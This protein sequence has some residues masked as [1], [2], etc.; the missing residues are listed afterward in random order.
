PYYRKQHTVDP[1]HELIQKR[2]REGLVRLL[3]ELSDSFNG[4]FL[5][6]AVATRAGWSQLADGALGLLDAFLA[7][8]DMRTNQGSLWNYDFRFIPVE[9][10]SGIY[11]T[12]LGDEQRE[13]GAYYTPP[14]KPYTTAHAARAF[15]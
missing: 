8:V 14:P 15:C 7:R 2:D 12:F 9:L 1:L 6:P 5:A 11:E 4:D 13:L 10:L 3:S